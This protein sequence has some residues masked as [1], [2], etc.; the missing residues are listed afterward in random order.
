MGDYPVV[1]NFMRNF[2]AL[3]EQ[4]KPTRV[5]FVLEGHP[6]AR[7]EA[8]PEYK[9]NR[10]IEIPEGEPVP[11][12]I[13]KKIVENENFFRQ[14]NLITDLL[15]KHFP[16]SVVRHADYECDDV[17]YNL[18]RR[19]SNAV[20]WTVVSNDSDFT[21]LLNEFSHVKIYNPMTKDYVQEPPFDYVTWK[22]LRGDGSDNIP[23]L[24]GIGDKTADSLVN[25][26]DKL[27][28]LFQDKLMA[29]TF[30]RNHALIKFHTWTDDDALK[31][32]SSSPIK[33]WT[34]VAKKFHEWMFASLLKDK[35]WDKYTSTFDA[36]WDNT[37]SLR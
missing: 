32:T 2:R 18:I 36:L 15:K 34:A 20:P 7:Y 3:V 5:Y 13:A 33:D 29:E 27:A 19:S 14:V 26:P 12:E 21:Q 30:S 8:L 35:S 1:F 4:H 37:Y 10:R 6:R 28:E 24:P 22:A 11:P 9:A 17:I 25:D 31:M 23:G 16:V